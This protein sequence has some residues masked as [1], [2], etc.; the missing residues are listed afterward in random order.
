MMSKLFF[1]FIFIATALNVSAA[2]KT[3]ISYGFSK[4]TKD[5]TMPKAADLI[6]CVGDAWGELIPCKRTCPA[7]TPDC[8]NNYDKGKTVHGGCAPLLGGKCNTGKMDDNSQQVCC[9][10]DNCNTNLKAKL[11]AAAKPAAAMGAIFVAAMAALWL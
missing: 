3:C 8:Y 6:A 11:D 5:V 9:I 2:P 10:T 1:S 7:K 4:N